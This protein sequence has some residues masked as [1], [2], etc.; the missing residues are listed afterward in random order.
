MTLKIK[1]VTF[2]LKT[3]AQSLPSITNDGEEIYKVASSLLRA[4]IKNAHPKALK[5]RLMGKEAPACKL[6]F[7]W[8][9]FCGLIESILSCLFWWGHWF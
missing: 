2:E 6:Q 1:S 9:Q 7:L 3:K 4:E 8:I 5:L